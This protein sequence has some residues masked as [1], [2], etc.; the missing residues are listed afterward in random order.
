MLKPQPAL[1]TIWRLSLTCAA[2]PP[3]FLI[4]LCLRIG[5]RAWSIA[6]VIWALLFLFL[7]LVYLPLKF[8]RLAFTLKNERLT[9]HSG[10]FYIRMREMP[11]EN[12]QYVG[13]LISPFDALFGLASVSVIAAGGRVL[14][15]GLRKQDALNLADMLPGREV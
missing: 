1:L 5:G 10:G 9:V 3:A 2:I 4:S 13:I 14:V 11:L 12:V 6:T 8:R 7:Y 15:P